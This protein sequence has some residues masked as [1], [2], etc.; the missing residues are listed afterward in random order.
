VTGNARIID[1]TKIDTSK[2]SIISRVKIKNKKKGMEVAYTIVSE[3]EVNLKEGKISVKSP[4][5]QGL[6]GKKVGEIAQIQAPGGKID[7]EILEISLQGHGKH[8][9]T[10]HLQGDSRSYHSRE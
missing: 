9:Y 1:G 2:V 3:E 10:Y 4:I 6:L 7:F 8:F 5:G